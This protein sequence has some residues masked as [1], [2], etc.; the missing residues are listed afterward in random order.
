MLEKYRYNVAR[1]ARCGICRAKYSEKVHYVCPVREHT[2]GFE[3]YFSRGRVAVA[4]GILEGAIDYS[5]ELVEV[6]Y[7]CLGCKSCVEQCGSVDMRNGKSLVDTAKIVREMRE[8]AIALGLEPKIMQE[9]HATVSKNKNTFGGSL[10]EKNKL[11]KKFELPDKGD[12]IFFSG[13]YG[14]YRDRKEAEAT[15]KI[16]KATGAA[17]AY[18]A[19]KEWCCGVMEYWGGNTKVA[20]DMAL[21]NMEALDAAGVKTLVTAC[22]G[23]LDTIKDIYPE[24]IE[25][26]LPFKVIHISEYLA[27]LVK[28]G[29]LKFTKEIN[30]T[31]TYHD[32]CH[33]GRHA[34]I[35]DAPRKVIESI[36]GITLKE[37]ERNR[38]ASGCCGSGIGAV[39]ALEPD[40]ALA[41]TNDRIKE[42]VA[43]GAEVLTSA[44]PMCVEQLTLAGRA[45]K[46][47]LEYINLPALVAEAMGL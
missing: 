25:D 21:H 34:R 38:E 12:T 17:P 35:F 16:L 1:C 47:K 31:V 29:E 9:L 13:C 22:S 10:E 36:P 2:G 7:T 23:C 11:A 44:C 27:D 42:A 39:R 3:H 24:I 40:L 43:T 18:L 32:P 5:P 15:I 28:K 46:A 26:K 4:A 19:D 20:R 6:L 33:L 37:M 8:D 41:I 14:V 45:A 30:K